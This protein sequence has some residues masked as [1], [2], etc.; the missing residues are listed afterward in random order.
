MSRKEPMGSSQDGEVLQFEVRVCNKYSSSE[1]QAPRIVQIK[2]FDILYNNQACNLFYLRDITRLIESRREKG[3]MRL[4]RDHNVLLFLN[5]P[6]Q[7]IADL[8]QHL[9]GELSRFA[10]DRLCSGLKD[11][12]YAI[13]DFVWLVAKMQ[14]RF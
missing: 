6:E 3:R 1:D 13:D 7:F 12:K 14:G 10:A 2:I 9:I 4:G 11:L 5:D 8:R